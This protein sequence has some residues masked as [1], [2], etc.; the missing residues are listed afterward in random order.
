M[1]FD[2]GFLTIPLLSLLAIFGFAV[3]TDTN[4]I[5]FEVKSVPQIA[6]DMGFDE[7]TVRDTIMFKIYDISRAA[8]IA[9]G[10]D[11]ATISDAQDQSLRNISETLGIEKGVMAAQGFLG[12][13]PYRIKGK[14]VQEGDVL[15]LIINGFSKDN[16]SFDFVLKTDQEVSQSAQIIQGHSGI[17]GIGTNDNIHLSITHTNMEIKALLNKSAEAIL[18]RIDPYLLARYYF[19]TESSQ[20]I[21]TKTIPQ[22]ARCLEVMPRSQKIWPLLLWGRTYQLRGEYA[23]AIEIYKKIYLMEPLF[24]FTLLRWGETLAALGQHKDAIALYQQAIYNSRYYPNYPAARSMTYSLWADSLIKMGQLDDAETVLLEGERGLFSNG[25]SSANAII[26]N[27]LG[28]FLMKYRHDYEHAEYHLRRA[29]YF[30]DNQKYYA[31]LQEVIAK[32]VPGYDTYL[33]MTRM[34]G[35]T[36]SDHSTH[37]TDTP[38][39]NT[40]TQPLAK[41]PN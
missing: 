3:M 12:L 7:N 34:Q 37:S 14:L 32:Q 24:P 38:Q 30:D 20:A 22:L 10:V 5:A 17:G 13:I 41:N 40:V 4:M 15:Y 1:M 28:C 18:N 21:F 16:H 11:Y 33:A 36:A 6:R 8:D 19:V 27:A 9:R 29:I 31:D 26:H 23:K 39:M 2:L 25:R 35:K